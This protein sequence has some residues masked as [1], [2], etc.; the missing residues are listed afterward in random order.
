M[1]LK[2]MFMIVL[3]DINKTKIVALKRGRTAAC[4]S[5]TGKRPRKAF[6]DRDILSI[7][8]IKKDQ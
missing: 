7:T 4:H 1:A 3:N 2:R 5:V 8:E 6:I